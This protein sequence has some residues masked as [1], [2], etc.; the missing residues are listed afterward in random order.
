MKKFIGI[1]L[2]FIVIVVIVLYFV[3][4]FLLKE[5]L[6]RKM[7]KVNNVFVIIGSV[8]LDYFE[9]YV[10]LKDI[11][12]MSN[13]YK[14]EIFIFID[15][16]KSYYE[17]DFRK[18]VIIFDDIEIDGIVFFKDVNYENSDREVVVIFEN[19]VIEVEEKI[20][21]DK[22]LMELKI[23]YFNKIEEN[24]LNFDEIFLR[25]LVN[26]DNISE[27]EKIK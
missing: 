9:G 6:E 7:L 11:K 4:D 18:K 15:E 16:L 23:F 25:D 19:K 21:R 17:I 12:V 14:D 1:L 27:F 24:Y 13:L 3:R 20:K 8:D 2:F 5:Y 22:V 10:I 26:K